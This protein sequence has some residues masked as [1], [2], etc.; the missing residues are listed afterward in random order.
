MKI[1]GIGLAKTGTTSLNAALQMMGYRAEHAIGNLS[2]VDQL[3]AVTDELARDYPELDA[4][5]PGSKFI[6]TV[7]ELESWLK[8]CAHHF[9]N[10]IPPDH[11]H[12]AYIQA[13]YGATV[14]DEPTFRQAYQRH[15]E[16]V[17]KHFQGR[18]N[19]LLILDVCGGEG[20]AKLC[21]FLG[22]EIPK[23]PFPRENV[24]R[25]VSRLM[26]RVKKMLGLGAKG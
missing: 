9:R 11:P 4:R 6:L 14:F 20:W 22:R 8:S 26:R 2:E 13:V 24:S 15:Y 19:D 25:S 5:Y 23:A 12:A 7:R 21:P 18:E 3:D 17:L 16:G 10:P 1:F